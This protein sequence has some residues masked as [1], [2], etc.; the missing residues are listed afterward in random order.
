MHALRFLRSHGLTL[1]EKNFRSRFGE[2]DLVMYEGDCLVFVEVRLR[3]A[4][5]FASAVESV[6]AWKCERLVR[7]AH[8]YLGCRGIGDQTACRFDVIGIDLGPGDKAR[9]DWRRDAFRGE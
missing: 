9:I 5:G 2:I 6:D 4:S 7:T 8:V 1:V 3:R